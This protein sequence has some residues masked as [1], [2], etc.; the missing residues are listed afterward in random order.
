MLLDTP[1][2]KS[3]IEAESSRNVF[4]SI[5]PTSTKAVRSE[6]YSEL[7]NIRYCIYEY[8]SLA[9]PVL[10]AQNQPVELTWMPKS[11]QAHKD[12]VTNVI[13]ADNHSLITTSV[14]G[15]VNVW[16]KAKFS[17]QRSMDCEAP[18][19]CLALVNGTLF[20]G[21]ES[22]LQLWDFQT[23]LK[24]QHVPQYEGCRVYSLTLLTGRGHQ[25][26]SVSFDSKV[27]LLSL[28]RDDSLYASSPH[29]PQGEDFH[30]AACLG[31]AVGDRV[32]WHMVDARGV[33]TLREYNANMTISS[34]PIHSIAFNAAPGCV[35][36]TEQHL[37][38]KSRGGDGGIASVRVWSVNDFTVVAD[39]IVPS[40]PLSTTIFLGDLLHTNHHR[41]YAYCAASGLVRIFD[42]KTLSEVGDVVLK[43]SYQLTSFHASRGGDLF[44]GLSDGKAKEW[45]ADIVME[46][47]IC[48]KALQLTEG[49]KERLSAPA[50]PSVP[51]LPPVVATEKALVCSVPWESDS[52]KGS[53]VDVSSVTSTYGGSNAGRD[54]SDSDLS[55][56]PT[57]TPPVTH[58]PAEKHISFAQ[59]P[60]DKPSMCHR[61]G[62]VD[63][64]TQC[65]D[66][67]VCSDALEE[68][69][70]VEKYALFNNGGVLAMVVMSLAWIAV[71]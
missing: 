4:I 27:D 10:N 58:Y 57:F 68:E 48:A 9:C 39:L 8:T 34:E 67:P 50:V 55:V 43:K 25:D 22:S 17:L 13:L 41:L 28:Q 70:D 71:L 42:L 37:C 69:G 11:I 6:I 44:A 20:V 15:I 54:L 24:I 30:H 60:M 51:V 31:E 12:A 66:C 5:R 40:S 47:I 19:H 64:F 49:D 26:L 61:A 53:A 65:C 45:A 2:V 1:E 29:H 3:A 35:C 59:S 56:S 33:S 38:A 18:V 23:H 16:D 62:L 63:N 32:F 46:S 21:T 52:S 14:D 36:L 7:S